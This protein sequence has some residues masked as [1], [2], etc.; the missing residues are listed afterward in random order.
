MTF[1]DDAHGSYWW[2]DVVDEL[3]FY[4]LQ[5]QSFDDLTRNYHRLTGNAPMLPRWALGYLSLI[6]I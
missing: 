5:G 3:S 1:H 6:H 2:A 4:I